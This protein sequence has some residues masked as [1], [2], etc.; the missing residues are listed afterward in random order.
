MKNNITTILE[1]FHNKWLHGMNTYE[2]VENFLI[3]TLK[4]Y[5]E[6]VRP[7]KEEY[8]DDEFDDGVN[9]AFFEFERANKKFWEDNKQ[10]YDN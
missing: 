5:S 3:S 6:A 8:P 10:T 9:H 4:L 1:E 7:S 2:E